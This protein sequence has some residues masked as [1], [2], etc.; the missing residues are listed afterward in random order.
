MDHHD[1]N[2]RYA[3]REMVWSVGPNQF[4]AQV[5]APLPAGRALDL[6]AGEG[7]NALWLAERGWRVTAVDFSE[8]AL[9]RAGGLAAERLDRPDALELV[10]ADLAE[11]LPPAAAFDLVLVVYLQVPAE[12]RRTVLRR[13]ADAVAPGGRLVVVT[14]DPDNLTRGYGGPGDPDVLYSAADV[15]ADVADCGLTV[16]RAEQVTRDVPTDAG[17]RTAVDALFV[18]RRPAVAG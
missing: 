13:A 1:W 5:V 14:H 6:A 4:V 15:A 12:L 9:G 17:S 10:P 8:V 2:A 3:S 11:Y 16:L 18:A 7:R